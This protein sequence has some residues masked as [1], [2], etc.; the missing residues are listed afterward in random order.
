MKVIHVISGLN[1]GGAEHVLFRLASSMNDVEHIVISLTDLG[2]YGPK[3]QEK[4]IKVKILNMPRGWVTL[5]G[6]WLLY[7][8]LKKE[9]P[10]VVQ[11]WMYHADLLGGLFARL[12]GCKKIYWG[13]RH[14]NL[15]KEVNSKSTL[16]VVRLCAFLSSILP[17]KIISCAERSVKIHQDFGYNGDF[18]VVPNGFDTH[19]FSPNKVLRD[20]TREAL[21][22]SNKITLGFVARWDPQKDHKNLLK[23]IKLVKNRYP[24]IFCVLI[25]QDCD[26]ENQIL[27]SLIDK[28]DIKENIILLGRRTDI[29]GIMN[30]LDL[31]VLSSVGEAFPSVVAEAMASGTP[32]IVTDVGDA[33]M[34]VGDTGWVVPIGNSEKLADTINLAINEMGD[35]EI[36][37]DRKEKCS[38]RVLE[39]F[40]LDKM[41]QSYKAIWLEK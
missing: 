38:N 34:I 25:G 5:K 21:N 23:A 10:D 22:T 4:N 37:Q 26:D 3:L 36:W 32:C 20:S 41:I 35:P 7:S 16:L 13:L 1:D 18:L 39:Q 9:E 24:D 27:S 8:I 6:L 40:S 12:A 19:L 11:T 33:G 28:L 15:T 17:T 30:A 2:K 29:P 14:S 31:H